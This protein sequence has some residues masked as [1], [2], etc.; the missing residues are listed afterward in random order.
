MFARRPWRAKNYYA[1]LA[2]ELVLLSNCNICYEIYT[3]ENNFVTKMRNHIPIALISLAMLFIGGIIYI[4]YRPHTLILFSW[5]ELLKID[6]LLP[7]DKTIF[8]SNSSFIKFVVF[9]LP[10]G[11]WLL[12]CILLIGIIWERSALAFLWYATS[13]SLISI[14]A[15]I[16]QLLNVIKGTFDIVDIFVVLCSYLVGV[17]VYYAFLW[18]KA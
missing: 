16:L 17:K 18:R 4:K 14:F 7:V 1:I 15:E 13:F 8:N 5:I 10:N 6:D 3:L 11:L 12:S 9:S 2:F